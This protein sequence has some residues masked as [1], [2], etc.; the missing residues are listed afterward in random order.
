MTSV[1]LSKREDGSMQSEFL[2][3]GDSCLFTELSYLRYKRHYSSQEW[4]YLDNLI[5]SGSVFCFHSQVSIL[6]SK[7]SMNIGIFLKQFKRWVSGSIFKVWLSLHN[8]RH[9]T[10]SNLCGMRH[11][12]LQRSCLMLVSL[13]KLTCPGRS[14]VH[15]S[16]APTGYVSLV[17]LTSVTWKYCKYAAKGYLAGIDQLLV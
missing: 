2:T 6:S 17:T 8:T 4:N 14:G 16:T 12:G 5:I 9:I 10:L 3:F 7:R 11:I 13:R 1:H 15:C